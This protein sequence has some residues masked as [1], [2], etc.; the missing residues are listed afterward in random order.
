M[1]T[2]IELCRG[3]S[4]H[5]AEGGN[6]WTGDAGQ[7]RRQGGGVRATTGDHEQVWHRPRPR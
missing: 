4:C 1:V 7:R 6:V 2:E 3:G 5:A